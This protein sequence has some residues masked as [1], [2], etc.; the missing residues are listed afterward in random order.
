VEG[1][2]KKKHRILPEKCVKC[3]VCYDVCNFDAVTVLSGPAAGKP[4][5]PV[6]VQG[7]K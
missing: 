6:A 5:A 2:A 1:E 7:G 4:D 3:G